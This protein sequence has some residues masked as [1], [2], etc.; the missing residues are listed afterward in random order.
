[1][2]RDISPAVA[3]H[4][5][6]VARITK[7]VKA[8]NR[9]PDELVDAKRDLVAANIAVYVEKTLAS[10]PPLTREQLDALHVLLEPVRQGGE[11]A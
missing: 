6:R 4:R 3:H 10:A 5:G 7:L 1:M 2:Q 11:L 8:G 9:T